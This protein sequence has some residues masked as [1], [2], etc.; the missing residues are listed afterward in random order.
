MLGK[1]TLLVEADLRRPSLSLRMKVE[2]S[3]GFASLLTGRDKEEKTIVAS[4][5][6]D[7]DVLPAGECPPDFNAELLANGVFSSCLTRWKQ[8]YDFVILDSPPVLPVADARIL[9]GQADGTIMVLR[10]SHTRR[11]EV[12]QAY[13]DL[14]AAGGRLMGTI[15][16]GVD[17]L[18][19]GGY[20]SDYS[21]G[22]PCLASSEIAVGASST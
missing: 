2:S 7:L 12:V 3:A 17:S 16:V 11:V 18:S 10:A 19:D 5:I 6:A 14:S 15:L 9:A 20:N 1:K 21:A 4:G 22:V 13:A 8:R